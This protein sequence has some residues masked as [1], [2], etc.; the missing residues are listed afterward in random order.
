[1][2]HWLVWLSG[3]QDGCPVDWFDWVAA[4]I[5]VQLTGLIEWLPGCLSSWLVWLSGCQD[6]CP[7]DWFDWVTARMAVQLTGLIEWLPGWLSS[8]LV[9]LSGCQDGWFLEWV[10]SSISRIQGSWRHFSKSENS[11]VSFQGA[12]HKGLFQ[13]PASTKYFYVPDEM[14]NWFQKMIFTYQNHVFAE[15]QNGP[16]G[17]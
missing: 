8:W 11:N 16:Y 9:W 1:M 13:K 17:S 5:A 4:R 2:I 14:E 15:H 12:S 3:C 7:A 10:V 6:G